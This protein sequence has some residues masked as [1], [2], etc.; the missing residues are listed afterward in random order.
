M[1]TSKFALEINW[2]LEGVQHSN[3][4]FHV[5]NLTMIYVC[6][7][8]TPKCIITIHWML[9][10]CSDDWCRNKPKNKIWML[11]CCN[12]YLFLAQNSVRFCLSKHNIQK[13]FAIKDFW[14]VVLPIHKPTLLNYY[15]SD[16]IRVPA[17]QAVIKQAR[18]PAQ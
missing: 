14:S 8:N 13:K 9:L 10:I 16:S 1:K 12:V 3:G 17:I 18:E 4:Y 5:K 11:K 7:F 15:Y 6:N 2:P